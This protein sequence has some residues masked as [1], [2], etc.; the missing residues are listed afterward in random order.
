MS[1]GHAFSLEFIHIANG[2][3]CS[4]TWPIIESSVT[5]VTSSLAL[6][7]RWVTTLKSQIHINFGRK[8]TRHPMNC[9]PSRLG[10]IGY[11]Y[12][13]YSMASRALY[14]NITHCPYISIL[15]KQSTHISISNCFQLTGLSMLLGCEYSLNN[16]RGPLP[17]FC[18]II[19]RC[20]CYIEEQRY[21]HSV[22]ST[23]MVHRSPRVPCL[24]ILTSPSLCPLYTAVFTRS[25]SG[26][27]LLA[28]TFNTAFYTGHS[29]V[30]I[31][32]DK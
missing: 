16:D 3:L 21:S 4:A 13:K 1:R 24:D 20:A 29:S 30:A 8:G 12:C 7:K 32:V 11:I 5:T 23:I 19:H 14:H 27:Q 22:K 15:D 10:L 18:L 2:G 31:I 9:L 17:A 28:S 26:A 25:G 6:G